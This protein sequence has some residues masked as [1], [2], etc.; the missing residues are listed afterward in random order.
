MPKTH[1]KKSRKLGI[2]LATLAMVSALL[3]LVIDYRLEVSQY[4]LKTMQL[5]DTASEYRIVHLSDLHYAWFGEGQ[6]TLIGAVAAQRPDLIVMTG[7]MID[8][9]SDSLAGIEALLQGIAPLAP[10]FS[11]SGNHE[12]SNMPLYIQLK[13][14]YK[15]YGVTELENEMVELRWQGMSIYIGGMPDGQLNRGRRSEIPLP[16]PPLGSL[17]ILLY[18]NTNQYEVITSMGLGYQYLFTGH[19]HGG[20]IRLPFIGGL[21]DNDHRFFPKYDSGVFNQRTP[22]MISS[23]GLGDPSSL[24]IPR[25][26]NRPEVVCVVLAPL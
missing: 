12:L 4:T 1:R 5:S 13:Q 9:K 11:V 17:G 6:K 20:I 16:S 23:R 7:D 21:L 3:L 10:I 19:T 8:R 14:L 25:V 15:D 18:H 24:P 26:N 22:T 2:I